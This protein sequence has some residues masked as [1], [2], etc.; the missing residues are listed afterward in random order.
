MWPYCTKK[1]FTFSGNVIDVQSG[2]WVG[3]MSGLGAGVDSFYEY[4]LKVPT[5]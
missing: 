4:L 5:L 3:K 1:V 2:E